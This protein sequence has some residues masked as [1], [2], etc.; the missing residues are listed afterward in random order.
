MPFKPPEKLLVE[1]DDSELLLIK[2][3]PQE[4]NKKEDTYQYE[5]TKSIKKENT[6]FEMTEVELKRNLKNFF[7]EI[8]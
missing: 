6:I 1:S 3:I 4:K 2:T 7:K 8:K 5:I